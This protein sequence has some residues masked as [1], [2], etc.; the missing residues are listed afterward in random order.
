V[1]RELPSAK[2]SITLPILVVGLEPDDETAT[3]DLT[4][5]HL[6]PLTSNDRSAIGAFTAGGATENRY[7]VVSAI[8]AGTPPSD[9]TPDSPVGL[10]AGT[11]GPSLTAVPDDSEEMP[12]PEGPQLDMRRASERAES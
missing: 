10:M 4:Q 5:C 9:L 6:R 3:Y 7:R 2:V 8:R 12:T 1:C 11:A